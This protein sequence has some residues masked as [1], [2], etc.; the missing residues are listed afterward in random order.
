M[1]KESGKMSTKLIIK[2]TS[3]TCL[4]QANLRATYLYKGQYFASAV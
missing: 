1:G 3:K 2:T 4:G